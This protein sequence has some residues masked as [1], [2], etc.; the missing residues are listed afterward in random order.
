MLRS[1]DP[2]AVQN[3]HK[4]NPCATECGAQH[5]C[6]TSIWAYLHTCITMRGVGR[7]TGPAACWPRPEESRLALHCECDSGGY[8]GD[9]PGAK[10]GSF[11][12]IASKGT[13]GEQRSKVRYAGTKDR[14]D[15]PMV[16]SEVSGL[17]Q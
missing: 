3:E 2:E 7:S 6:R 15:V 9:G 8:A 10:A 13:T 5:Y 1:G 16:Q 11:V 12:L 14:E 4:D 17:L